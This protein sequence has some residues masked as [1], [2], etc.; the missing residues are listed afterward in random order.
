MASGYPL[1]TFLHERCMSKFC[2]N[3]YCVYTAIYMHALTFPCT[4]KNTCHFIRTLH[5]TLSKVWKYD[6]RDSEDFYRSTNLKGSWCP[7][8]TTVSEEK[9]DIV[10][11]CC[12]ASKIACA[13]NPR[14]CPG[15]NR[16]LVN[17]AASRGQHVVKCVLNPGIVAALNPHYLPPS[18][19]GRGPSHH[20]VWTLSSLDEY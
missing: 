16:H 13:L 20:S 8:T 1:A 7:Q 12:P 17:S 18:C 14:S 15:W 10:P 11:R 3:S 6:D 19:G 5:I 2:W 4:Y 9:K